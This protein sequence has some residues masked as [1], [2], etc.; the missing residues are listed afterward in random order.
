MQHRAE[1]DKR[2]NAGDL[3]T[4][5]SDEASRQVTIRDNRPNDKITQKTKDNNTFIA[6]YKMSYARVKVIT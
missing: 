5:C 1:Q 2:R 3:P 4:R 6:R